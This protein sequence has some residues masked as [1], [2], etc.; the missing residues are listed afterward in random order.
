MKRI[1]IT[2]LLILL[3]FSTET[4]KTKTVSTPAKGYE[5][6]DGGKSEKNEVTVYFDYN[7]DFCLKP[8][9]LKKGTH[10]KNYNSSDDSIVIKTGDKYVLPQ[11]FMEGYTFV[12]W[13]FREMPSGNGFWGN[14][15]TEDTV[16]TIKESHT[17]FAVWKANTYRVSLDFNFNGMLPSTP[18]IDAFTN[19]ESTEFEVIYGNTF[20]F[21][22][23]PMREGYSF[24]G[25]FRQEKDNVGYGEKVENDS[26]FDE[27]KE[28]VLY[29]GWEPIRIKISFDMM[30]GKETE[31]KTIAYGEKLEKVLFEPQKAGYEFIG[32]NTSVDGSGMNV[33]DKD[34]SR[35]TRDARIYAM[36]RPLSYDIELDYNLKWKLEAVKAK[37]IGD[38]K[39]TLT[40]GKSFPK[41]PSPEREG[42]YFMGWY[43]M[44]DDGSF[45]ERITPSSKVDERCEKG[46]KA[47]WIPE[48]VKVIYDYN[49][50]E[51]E[52]E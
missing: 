20:D 48:L 31:E 27:A 15:C 36:Y 32:W 50:Y 41:L 2:V 1:I 52:G 25:W 7:S 30:N 37:G 14:Y 6:N 26:I 38:K 11:P 33:G 13:S 49:V 17:L 19:M 46:L 40:A 21:L 47:R 18:G 44:N 29:A 16:C 24:L 45:G 8:E 39:I 51:Y 12:G 3:L 5:S 9:M 4:W 42:Y 23:E 10:G 22:C 28:Y 43:I 34:V 35:F